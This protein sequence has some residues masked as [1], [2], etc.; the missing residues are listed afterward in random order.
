MQAGDS[1]P[2]VPPHSEQGDRSPRPARRVWYVLWRL[3]APTI[4]AILLVAMTVPLGNWQ[5]RRAEYK[6]AVIA[7]QEAARALPAVTLEAGQPERARELAE[8][9]R[10][11]RLHGV[12]LDD[13]TVFLDNSIVNGRAGFLV[14]TPLVP[15]GDIRSP[16]I[17]VVRGWAAADPA[18]REVAPVVRAPTGEISIEGYARD[19]LP[20]RFELKR[21]PPPAPGQKVWQSLSRET[22]AQWSGLALM[23]LVVE[24]LQPA[25]AANGL[26]ADDGLV[27][28][29]SAPLLDS[30][31]NRSYAFQWYS[32]AALAAGLWVWF[33]L[34]PALKGY[35]RAGG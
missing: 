7:R 23:P 1:S 32:F 3:V 11:V 13:R 24:Q 14:V 2:A 34:R 33:V 4:G 26:A 12:L 29:H 25:R 5:L 8:E 21:A 35:R 19:D 9:G 27:H 20:K 22:Y 30:Y 15:A 28:E 18:H 17:L 16:A 31:K 6:E 10:R